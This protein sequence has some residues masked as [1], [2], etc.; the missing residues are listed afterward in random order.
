[1][2]NKKC[3]QDRSAFT[4]IELLVVISIIAVLMSIMMPALRKVR[5]QGMDVVCRSN[6]KQNA[7]CFGMYL[8]DNNNRYFTSCFMVDSS[9]GIP[10]NWFRAIMDYM[11]GSYD[12]KLLLCPTTKK[13]Q[14]QNSTLI[15]P[16]AAYD[17]SLDFGND[18]PLFSYGSNDWILSSWNGGEYPPVEKKMAWRT[19]MVAGESPS[20]IPVLGDASYPIATDVRFLFVPEEVP[21]YGDHYWK[22]TTG[23][24]KQMKR[25]CLDRHNLS[26]NWNFM[27]LSVKKV[28][29]KQLWEIPF[30]RGWNPNNMDVRTR[31]Q[32]K[33]WMKGGKDYP[34]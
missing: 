30:H 22:N 25:F 31:V 20:K 11:G 9:G 17:A 21:D 16:R 18:L 6:L 13:V 24:G 34:I 29:L 12:D 7:L 4:L 5:E 27:D 8:Q 28:G 2:L 32:W 15:D 3:K 33:E 23:S 1:M 14:Q 19:S 26:V 10:N